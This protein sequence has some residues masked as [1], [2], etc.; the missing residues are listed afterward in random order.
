MTPAAVYV[1]AIAM[2]YQGLHQYPNSTQFVT[3]PRTVS[4]R[5]VVRTSK[6]YRSELEP[7]QTHYSE[8]RQ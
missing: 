8:R 7:I 2:L 4:T 1:R 6:V 3:S 5:S